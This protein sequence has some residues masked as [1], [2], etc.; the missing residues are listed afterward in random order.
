MLLQ[1][2]AHQQHMTSGNKIEKVI[3]NC[4]PL[5][6][7]KEVGYAIIITRGARAN[8]YPMDSA[9]QNLTYSTTNFAL[10]IDVPLPLYTYTGFFPACDSIGISF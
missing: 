6:T 4:P 3:T 8:T 5:S 9:H 1:D 2:G 7:T 10:F